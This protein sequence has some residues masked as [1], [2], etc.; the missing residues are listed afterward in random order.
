MTKRAQLLAPTRFLFGVLAAACANTGETPTP[1]FCGDGILERGEQCDPPT[2]GSCSDQCHI[3]PS[4]FNQCPELTWLFVA[5][6][7]TAVGGEIA[8]EAQATDPDGDKVKLTWSAD[9][10]QFGKKS[11]GS[12]HYTC[13]KKGSRTLTL[14]FTDSGGCTM[15]KTVEVECAP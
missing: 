12:T 8:V 13:S 2:S 5:P 4:T 7:R 3:L 15:T 6:L 9:Q 14:S 1:P 10:G 11:A